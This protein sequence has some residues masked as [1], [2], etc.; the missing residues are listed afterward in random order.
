[1]SVARLRDSAQYVKGVGPRRYEYLK[2]LGLQRVWDILW[3]APRHYFDRTSV[4]E[5][6]RLIPG[7]EATI[8]GRVQ[9]VTLER[10]PRGWQIVKARLE[11]ETGTIPVIW[12]NQAY[13][14]NVLRPGQ[15]L[16]LTGKVVYGRSNL[17]LRVN[18]FEIVEQGH[19][20]NAARIVPVY[21]ATEGLSQKV[22]R[23][24]VHQVLH[25]YAGCYPEV[26]AREVRER[27]KLEDIQ[28]AWMNLHFP[29][30]FTR[31]EKARRRLAFEEL[32]LW[33][34][35]V[36]KKRAAQRATLPA[37]RSH[38]G[39]DELVRMVRNS[40]PFELTAAQ[41]QVVGEIFADLISDQPM[42]RLLQ[43]D[44]GAGKTV[45]AVLAAAKVAGNGFQTAFMAPTEILA[46]QHYQALCRFMGRT[47]VRVGLLTG[48]TPPREKAEILAMV[49]RGE[50]GILV[51]THSLIQEQVRFARLGLVVI[52]EQ[53]RFG[54]RQRGMLLDKGDWCPDMLV[55]SATPIPRTLA[56]AYYGD[57]DISVIDQLPPGRRPV[58]TF[59]LKPGLEG[60]LHG[61]I[62]R[63]V[64]DGRQVYVVCPLVEESEKQ[65]LQAATTL[66]KEL[67]TRVFPDLRIGLL[68][69]RM[70][71]EEKKA[72][73]ASFRKGE[74]DILVTT[75]ILEVGID[76]PN[77][78][79]M[80]VQHAERFGLSQLH[81]LRGRVGRGD[82]QSYC[83]LV[84]EPHTE[85]GWKRLKAMEKTGNGFEIAWQDLQMRGPGDFWGVRQHGLPALKVADLARDAHL[86]EAVRAELLT[87]VGYDEPKLCSIADLYTGEE[88]LIY[89]N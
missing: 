63:Q 43:G 47:P 7:R 84:G 38:S 54:V 53:Q 32:L 15:V 79:V 80:V 1:M 35:A 76:V 27:Y 77:A 61:F 2:R 87:G 14:K 4:E 46:V 3:Y 13:L 28:V 12:F 42:S 33:Q 72:V 89:K 85:E 25:D 73:A 30:D 75:S 17:E 22:L 39:G 31:L 78:T 62:R 18:E 71:S 10:S 19:V 56:L 34:W 67:A 16:L 41:E 48:K 5:I 86:L 37:G 60:R 65:D 66:Q 23:S 20:L 9:K 58:K 49:E 55:M 40:L 74:V 24:V 82:V 26:L 45:V 59:L 21:R 70:K 50:I 88:K 64:E 29:E 69:G 44:V 57:L 83:I 6:G 81:Q 36:Q 68:H 11:D 8:R 52:D 51:G